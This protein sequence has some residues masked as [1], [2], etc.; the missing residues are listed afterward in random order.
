MHQKAYEASQHFK[1]SNLS[2]F[3]EQSFLNFFSNHI[4]DAV[5][6][7]VCESLVHGSVSYSVAMAFSLR[8]G[9]SE[10]VNKLHLKQIQETLSYIN[11]LGLDGYCHNINRYRDFK[12][13]W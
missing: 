13:S 7:R 10:F 12:A 9:M 2:E 11:P 5:D 1:C 6:F 8:L 4:L 3:Y